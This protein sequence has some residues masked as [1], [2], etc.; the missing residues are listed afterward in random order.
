MSITKRLPRNYWNDEKILKI[1]L[2]Y[3]YKDIFI[4]NEPKAYDAAIKRNILDRIFNHMENS[5]K[6][7]WTYKEIKKEAKKYSNYNEFISNNEYVYKKIIEN[8]WYELITHLEKRFIWCFKEVKKVSSYYSSKSD[9]YKNYPG[10]YNWAKRNNCFEKITKH[11]DNLTS[12]GEERIKQFLIKSQINFTQQKRFKKCK[13]IHTLPFDFYI[14]DYNTCIE[15]DGKH[16]F[17]P[18]KYFGGKKRHLE[19]KHNDNIKNQYCI[20]NNIRLIRIPYYKFKEINEIL[21]NKFAYDL[22][23]RL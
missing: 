20:E 23:L 4:K 2:K 15:Y 5:S 17:Q 18:V 3:H 22:E 7:K 14:R 9:F 11:M 21:E 1:A 13:N 8:E 16:H 10:A 12:L 6:L 19:T